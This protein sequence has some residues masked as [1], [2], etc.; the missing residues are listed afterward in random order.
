MSASKAIWEEVLPK[1]FLGKNRDKGLTP[2][3]FAFSS[4]LSPLTVAFKSLSA[5]YT[6]KGLLIIG[7]EQY[8]CV[9]FTHSWF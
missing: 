2:P 6:F 7:C 8:M 1:V 4:S 9:S 5:S 3:A